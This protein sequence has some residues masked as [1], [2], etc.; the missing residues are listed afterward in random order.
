MDPSRSISETSSE[1]TILF[2]SIQKTQKDRRQRDLSQL[3]HTLLA[4]RPYYNEHVS[5]EVTIHNMHSTDV[6]IGV[7]PVSADESLLAHIQRHPVVIPQLLCDVCRDA[8]SIQHSITVV[9]PPSSAQS[10]V[11]LSSSSLA[12]P[13]PSLTSSHSPA[14]HSHT[15]TPP[16]SDVFLFPVPP[17][18]HFS[19][20]S[21]LGTLRQAITLNQTGRLYLGGDVC[22]MLLLPPLSLLS[23]FFLP[24][25]HSPSLLPPTHPLFSLPL[26]LSPSAAL[27]VGLSRS[28]M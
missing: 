11:P 8:L 10:D 13:L 9:A 24:P 26:T 23:H 3:P 21:S 2:P 20:R 25:S 22:L 19:I 27:S 18:S 1:P 12:S 17:L 6:F 16:I 28:A 4:I 7:L 5:F 15:S 14:H